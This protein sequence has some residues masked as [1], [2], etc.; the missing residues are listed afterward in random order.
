MGGDK[1]GGIRSVSSFYNF[2]SF[3]MLQFQNETEV[4]S[5]KKGLLLFNQKDFF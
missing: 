2:I 3:E 5:K 4:C 1:N